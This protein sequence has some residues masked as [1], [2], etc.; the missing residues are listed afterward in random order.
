MKS[1]ILIWIGLF[2]G[3]TVG[4]MISSLWGDG[5]LTLSSVLL[6]AVGGFVGIWIGFKLS[7]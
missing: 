1:N 5:F 7:N 3:S 4:G 2:A 6:T